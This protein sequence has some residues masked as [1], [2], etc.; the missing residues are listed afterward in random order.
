M[1]LDKQNL[2]ETMQH[3]DTQL[4]LDLAQ[5]ELK[6]CQGFGQLFDDLER[7]QGE[8]DRTKAEL[9]ETKLILAHNEL[10]LRSQKETAKQSLRP[11]HEKAR[12]SETRI[13]SLRR[14]MEKQQFANDKR[15]SRLEEK[16]DKAC[17]V[18]HMQSV[19][20]R[21]GANS[22]VQMAGCFTAVSFDKDAM[23]KLRAFVRSM[24][25]KEGT[26]F[27]DGLKIPQDSGEVEVGDGV[28]EDLEII[29]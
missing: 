28:V 10:L 9:R 18:Y 26:L 3:N 29:M 1:K 8:L 24:E 22:C 16:V 12:V 11:L 27:R 6:L 5:K 2:L 14:D 23:V 17:L 21:L 19:G 7:T 4:R 13:N 20:F 25:G 15:A